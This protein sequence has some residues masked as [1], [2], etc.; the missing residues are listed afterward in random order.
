MGEH[1]AEAESLAVMAAGMRYVNVPMNGFETPRNEQITKILDL[2]A[3]STEP[4]FIHCKLGR[5]RTGTVVAAYRIAHDR[6]E[7]KR[8]LDE[9]LDCGM[10]W[11]SRG[12]KRFIQDYQPAADPMALKPAASER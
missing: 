11:F 1:S 6:W 3:S 4:A 8:A 7:N 2:L 10:Q 12:M 5:D 9:A